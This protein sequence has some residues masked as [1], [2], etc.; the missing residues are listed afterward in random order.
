MPICTRTHARAYMGSQGLHALHNTKNSLLAAYATLAVKT[1]RNILNLTQHYA[2]TH[3]HPRSRAHMH[4]DM[5]RHGC[6]SITTTKHKHK[7]HKSLSRGVKGP[8]SK[9]QALLS[10]LGAVK[11]S[12]KVSKPTQQAC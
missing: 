1:Q 3:A 10:T 5:G 7:H 9:G 8:A 2:C 4:V 11:Q 12:Q 6:S